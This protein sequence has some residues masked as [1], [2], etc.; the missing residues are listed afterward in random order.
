MYNGSNSST[1]AYIRLNEHPETTK[2]KSLTEGQQ[3]HLDMELLYMCARPEVCVLR[4]TALQPGDRTTNS[5]AAERVFVQDYKDPHAVGRGCHAR[6]SALARMFVIR[7]PGVHLLQKTSDDSRV[8]TSGITPD[9]KIGLP[10]LDRSGP[11]GIFR[12]PRDPRT[13]FCLVLGQI[14]TKTNAD[15][16]PARAQGT[17]KGP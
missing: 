16:Q 1:S 14:E 5:S 12:L 13:H 7:N 9:P 10:L 4:R 3:A 11:A 2:G 6:P 17:K 8:L 15:Y